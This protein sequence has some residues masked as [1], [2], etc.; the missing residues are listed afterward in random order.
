M[1]L[2]IGAVMLLITAFLVHKFVPETVED[3]T[4]SKVPLRHR[5]AIVNGGRVATV[6][7]SLGLLFSTSYVD[8][9]AG[10][11]GV[12]KKIYG[13]QSLEG[14][15][16]IATKGEKGYQAEVIPPGFH[17]IPLVRVIYKVETFP[18]VDIPEGHYGVLE[19]RDGRTLPQGEIMAPLWA[20]GDE[21]NML[22]AQYFLES[23]R[24]YKG[25]QLSV[26]TPGKYRVNPYLFRVRYSTG[27]QT[28]I[29]DDKGYRTESGGIGPKKLDNTRVVHVQAG[30]VG[31]VRSNVLSD[32]NLDCRPQEKAVADTDG[33]IS[34]PLVPNGCKGVWSQALKPGAYFMNTL[35][36]DITDI[37]TRVQT[38][39]YAGGYERRY[40]DLD[41]EEDGTI[42]QNVRRVKVPELTTNADRAVFAK[43][44]NGWEV[45]IEMRVVVQVSPE[46]APIVVAAVGGLDQVEDRILT[47]AIRSI[48]RNVF[49]YDIETSD[50]AKR[51]EVLDLISNRTVIES[52][53]ERLVRVEGLKAGVGIKEVRMGEPVLPPEL[54]VGFRIEEVAEKMR[55]ATIKQKEFQTARIDTEKQKAEADRQDE[56][57]AAQI[58]A[59]RAV[60]EAEQQRL[61]G[62]GAYNRAVEEA[63]AERARGEGIR[64]R[65]IA[66]AEGQRA[67]AGVL[68]QDL[69]AE[70]KQLELILAMLKDNPELL[71]TVEKFV[72]QTLVTTGAGGE[73]NGSLTEALAVFG[74]LSK[75]QQEKKD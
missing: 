38:W 43:T 50:G 36:Y 75:E 28:H 10:E 16:I 1:F 64:D 4:G 49:G 34:V 54:L 33:A 58:G 21:Q 63:K 7:A 48:G 46:N 35:A 13:T 9:N 68:G 6:L 61:V 71:D 66:E 18:E 67:Q 45:P 30:Y 19:A 60:Q 17:I 73:H 72:P 62:V 26:L 69:T 37:D 15:Q 57:M 14:G 74:V 24:G 32:L 55:V 11:V 44:E 42:T 29:Y 22:N 41:V 2:I 23:G 56:L 59:E 12:L 51:I 39:K 3:Y 53:L 25:P 5:G 31:V 47:P 27:D 20:V 40:I 70:L 8:I 65:L 52:M